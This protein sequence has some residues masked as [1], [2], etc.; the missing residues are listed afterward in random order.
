MVTFHSKF[1]LIFTEGTDK[2]VNMNEYLGWIP[3]KKENE[4]IMK[5]SKR[6][7]LP[8]HM[9]GLRGLNNLGST[10]FMNCILQ[11]FIHNPFLRNYFLSDKHNRTVCIERKKNGTCLGCEMDYLF[12]QVFCGS[13]IPFSPYHFLY[14]VWKYAKYVAGYEQQ[15]AHE[16]FIAVINGVHLHISNSNSSHR[17]EESKDP[18]DFFK[19]RD[20]K[21]IVHKVF[22]GTLRSDVTCSYCGHISTAYDPFFD[23][24]LDLKLKNVNPPPT[25]NDLPNGKETQANG[26]LNF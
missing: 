20:C 10:C 7:M 5:H 18:R 16:F 9:Q 15:D 23:I 24:S 3:S 19:E 8:E 6:Y 25:P 13:I 2:Q 17:T 12:T 4:I 26:I 11:S 21:C 22:N 14:S 1:L